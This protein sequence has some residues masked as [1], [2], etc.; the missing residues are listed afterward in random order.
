MHR[1]GWRLPALRVLSA[2]GRWPEGKARVSDSERRM[3]HLQEIVHHNS[4][5]IWEVDAQGR[6]TFCSHACEAL[7]GF[8]PA[9]LLGRTP[10]ELMP[11]AEAERV[12]REFAAIVAERRAFRGLLNRN[13]R[14]D[15]RIVVLETSGVPLF[16]EH[17]EL[18]GYRGIDRDVTPGN[19]AGA[20]APDQRLFQLEAL[21]AAAPVALCLIDREHRYV[22]VNE[23]MARLRGMR[24]QEMAGR[25]VAELSAQAGIDAVDDFALLDAGKDVPDR[26]V[27]WDG[28]TCH[29]RVQA[30]R[31]LDGAVIALTMALTDITEHL[32]VQQRLARTTEALAEANRLLEDANRQLQ[33][34]AKHDHLTGIANRRGFDRAFERALAGMRDGAGALSVLMLDVDYFKQYN[35]HYGHPQGD[36]CL[37]QLAAVLQ[38]VACRPDDLVARYGGEE[39]AMLLPATPR[40]GAED[41]AARIQQEL[42]A[43]A[44]AH[45]G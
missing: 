15:G 28:R 6:Y 16:D 22:A 11:A 41:V 40:A 32:R 43:A 35:D 33:R 21:Y 30:V 36:Q 18:R 31:D 5:W 24:V 2:A 10:F 25:P 8:T 4:D 27:D 23:A 7:L 29:V 37:R 34:H 26:T 44:L 19:A 9:Q 3:R 1:R 45:A 20:G 39:F 12:G 13:L 38:R 42:Q 14:A 17:G